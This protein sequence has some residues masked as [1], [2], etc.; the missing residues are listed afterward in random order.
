MLVVILGYC[1]TKFCLHTNFKYCNV[2]GKQ[3]IQAQV[4][5]T[6]YDYYTGK[7]KADIWLE[8]PDYHKELSEFHTHTY[9]KSIGVKE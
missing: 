7:R 4:I 3:L 8:C 9:Y 1:I 6:Y 2:C 5:A